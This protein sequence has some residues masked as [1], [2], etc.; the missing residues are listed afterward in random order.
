MNKKFDSLQSKLIF[1][2][3]VILV[4]IVIAVLTSLITTYTDKAD[5]KSQMLAVSQYA[6]NQSIR[7]EELAAEDTTRSL[8]DVSDKAFSG[9]S[10]IDYSA[11]DF[12]VELRAFAESNRMDGV[13]VTEAT[14]R[15]AVALKGTYY[16]H[17][18]ELQD[19]WLA[20]IN[21]Y[22][23]VKDDPLKSY[24]DRLLVDGYY[25]DYALVARADLKGAFLCYKRQRVDAVEDDRFSLATLLNGFVFGSN[26]TIVITD[27]TNVLASNVNG[28]VGKLAENTDVVR[29]F[30][31]NDTYDDLIKVADGGD[32]YGVRTKC[33]DMYI[34]TYM[35]SETVFARRMII[36][37]MAFM[38]YVCAVIVILVVRQS[39]LSRKRAEQ[40]RI[41]E[42]YRMERERLAQQA[43]MANDAKTEFLRRMSHD[44]RTPINGILGMINIGDYYPDD[45]DKQTECRD[46]I[47]DATQYLL[48]LVN[49]ILYMNKLSTEGPAWKDEKFRMSELLEEVDSFMGTQAREAGITFTA[50]RDDI[51][52]DFVFGGQLQLK[53]VCTNLIGNAIKYNKPGGSVTASAHEVDF[54]DGYATYEFKI[55]DTGVGMSE[56]FMQRMYDPFERESNQD[57]KTMEGV[58]LGLSIVKKLVTKAGWNLSVE[59][60]RGVGTTFTLRAKFKVVDEW[61]KAPDDLSDENLR[62]K[63]YNILVAEDNDLNYDIIEFFLQVAGADIMRAT[64]G[65]EAIELF[66][67]SEE[68]DIDVILMDVMMPE[69]DGLAAT[70]AIR[71]LERDDAATVPIIAMTAS[72]FAEDVVKSRL[73]GMNAHLAKPVDCG[74]LIECILN[75]KNNPDNGG[76]AQ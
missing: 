58:G 51:E 68:G 37:V 48:E 25:Y 34:Y 31:K 1:F 20:C 12:L 4:G 10:A 21:T 41:D 26:G 49:D 24:D 59:S 54:A 52:H 62:L 71:R 39:I 13:V 57:G 9:R 40:E 6:K 2:A 63:G 76:G 29:E 17:G 23:S 60:K 32:Y 3:V 66:E 28:L 56:E 74:K 15:D 7:Y 33:R 67:Q 43:I 11:E 16:V 61:E 5:A 73:A 27:G 53:R 70:R 45:L 50:D 64:N 38:F 47:R 75:V 30:R 22:V 46:K 19:T 69:T 14:D 35:P 18:A 44:L 36:S 72:A 65:K 8:F 55:A 42:R